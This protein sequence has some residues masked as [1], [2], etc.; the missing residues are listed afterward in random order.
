MKHKT[1]LHNRVEHKPTCMAS[2]QSTQADCSIRSFS[3][4]SW[5]YKS[6]SH[7]QNKLRSCI[8]TV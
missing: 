1:N 8:R 6:W 2:M 3:D 5:W 7:Q 4:W